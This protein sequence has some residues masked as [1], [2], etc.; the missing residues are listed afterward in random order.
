[1]KELRGIIHQATK[2]RIMHASQTHV[3]EVIVQ[4]EINHL[5]VCAQRGLLELLAVKRLIYAEAIPVYMVT[6]PVN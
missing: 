1:V 6:V 3:M 4:V 5:P 2:S